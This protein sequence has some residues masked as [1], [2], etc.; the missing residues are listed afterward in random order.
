LIL[1]EFIYRLKRKIF[2]YYLKWITTWVISFLNRRKYKNISYFCLFVG[3]PRTGHTLIAALLDAHPNMAFGIEL[4]AIQYYKLGFNRDQIIYSLI[5][6]SKD[7]TEK[8]KN[9]WTNYSYKVKDTHQ[10]TYE[11]LKIIGDKYSIGVTL[12]L[13]KN[14]NILEDFNKKIKI[15]LKL[16]HVIR[17][18]F[19]T[20]TTMLK[21]KYEKYNITTPS[22]FELLNMI[23]IYFDKVRVI[24]ELR[25]K[26]KFDIFD[27]YHEEFIE[28]PYQGL[29]DLVRFLGES[30]TDEYLKKCSKI[31]YDEPHRSRFE[32]KWPPEIIEFVEKA[33]KDYDF[34]Q[35]YSYS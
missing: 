23:Y 3:Y 9:M 17:N 27:I 22:D 6:K 25:G 24:D 13:K 31:V 26:K 5:K 11:K 12:W 10:G 14:N 20:I 35:K 2:K 34:L 16:I 19:D 28:N 29:N 15:P 7:F 4:D 21:R 32:I 1:N 8:N 18:P 30:A 33:I